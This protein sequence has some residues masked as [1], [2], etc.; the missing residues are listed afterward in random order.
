MKTYQFVE[1][2]HTGGDA[3]I[4]ITD[5]K[6]LTHMKREYPDSPF[7]DEGLIDNFVIT[8]WAWEKKEEKE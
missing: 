5:E 1:P 8:N 3:L 6:I 7:S 4:T 2:H